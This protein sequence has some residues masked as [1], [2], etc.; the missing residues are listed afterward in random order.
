MAL[1]DDLRPLL[2]RIR[3]IPG[4]LGLRPYSVA[5]RVRTYSG[6]TLGL[7]Q[8]SDE[9]IAITE[10]GGQPPKVRW[11]DDEQIALAGYKTAGIEVGPMTPAHSGGGT[12]LATLT[13]AGVLDR[14]EVHLVITGPEHPEGANYRVTS[15]RTDRA[16]RY[17]VRAERVAD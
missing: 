15:I 2:T 10:D 9:T 6:D 13:Q 3:A 8:P 7:G 5:M 4:E 16:L 17:M 12:E 14:S 1:A 11:L